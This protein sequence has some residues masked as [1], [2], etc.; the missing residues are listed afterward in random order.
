MNENRGAK[1]TLLE[2]GITSKHTEKAKS[3]FVV[4]GS[5]LEVFSRTH[6]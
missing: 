3:I 2:R 1:S 6:V 4:D 5:E